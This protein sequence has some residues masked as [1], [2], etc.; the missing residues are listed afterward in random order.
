MRRYFTGIIFL[1]LLFTAR[2]SLSQGFSPYSR[3]GLGYLPSDVFSSTR[4]MGGIATGYSSAFHINHTNPASYADIAITTFEVG[5]NVDAATV[6]T[7]DSAYNG[8]NGTVSHVAIGVP[9]IRNK[10]GLSFGLLPYSFLNYDFANKDVDTSKVYTGKGSLYQLYVGTAYR[11]KDFSIGINGGYVFGKLDYTKGFAFTD[12]IGAYN[13]QNATSLKV[14]GFVYNIGIQYKKRVLKKSPQNSLKSD[15][16]ITAGAQGTT[17]V[18]LNART[19]SQWQ[20]YINLSDVPTVIDTPLSYAEQKG[21]VTIPY[22][23]S[24]G[25]TAGNENWWLVGIDFKYAGWSRF[26][27]SLNDYVLKEI[28]RAHV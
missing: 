25:L 17:S 5:V 1:A 22:N 11:I 9:L 2:E 21:K 28:G 8:V 3:Y 20:R 26:A 14:G 6:H 27:Y 16:F 24:L 15:I 18:R 4:A 7:K 13:V 10:W 12:S 23:F 19:S